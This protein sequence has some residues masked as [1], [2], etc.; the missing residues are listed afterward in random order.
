MKADE[1]NKKLDELIFKTVGREK[2]TFDFDKWKQTHKGEIQIYKS[3]IN[4][5]QISHSAQ[6]FGIWRIIMKSK[7]SKIAAA[8]MIII[9]AAVCVQHFGGSFRATSTA[10][11]ITDLPH[12]L[13]E[14]RTLHV[15]STAYLYEP[16]AEQP[17]FDEATVI[18]CELWLDVPDMRE[19]FVSYMSWSRPNGK[20]GLNKVEGFRDRD[21]AMDIDHT[22][23]TVRFNKVSMVKRRL[24]MRDTIQRYLNRI[25]EEQLDHF[26]KVGQ[27]TINGIIFDIWE[28]EDIDIHD[29]QTRKRIKC[30]LAPATGELG[31][32]YIWQKNGERDWRLGWCADTIE[33][34]IDI[35]DSVFEFNVPEDYKYNNTLENA[36]VG[37]G[38]GAGWSRM[39]GARVCLAI[40]FTLDDGS[41]I[42][43]WHS[44][45]LQKDRYE[46]QGHL[47]QDLVPGSE[48]PKLPM[49]IYGLK[50]IRKES[51]SP[52]ETFYVGR[53]L[54]FTKKDRWY[55]EWALFVLKEPLPLTTERRTY[56]MLCEFN[57]PSEQPPEVGN[58]M[59]ENKIEAEEFDTFVRGAMAELSD[60]C[61]VPEHV[62]YQKVMELAEQ[63]RSSIN[64]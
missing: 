21:L 37:E 45:D 20:K 10:Y 7:V 18:P 38:L 63:I 44:D 48:L 30:W 6:A 11:G 39:G 60:S 55:Y 59:S 12:L 62:T 46:E 31:R 64:P 34:D 4:G 61:T 56:R 35:A 27:E 51:Y 57:L 8:A 53:H 32:I 52:P 29:A 1:S 36:Y 22:E 5:R 23:K 28:R 14:T 49:V 13:S 58:P 40:N 42:V 19:H 3:Q 43:A 9:A 54:A 2:P 24:A 41:V 25:T 47:F 17:E 15:R 33:R 50:T 16:D 26:I